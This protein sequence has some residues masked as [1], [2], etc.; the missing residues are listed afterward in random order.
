MQANGQVEATERLLLDEYESCSDKTKVYAMFHLQS[1][2][3]IY[4]NSGQLEQ[5]KQ[6]AQVLLQGATRSGIGI[7]KS[8]GD[9]LLGMVY[10][11]RNELEAAAQHFTQIFENPY[12][13][14][15]SPYRD[16]LAALA[17]IHQIRGEGIEAWQMVESISRFDLEL[18]GSE[19]Q[20]TRS[21]RAR[22]QLLQGDL[23]GAS[24]WVA[25]FT[26]PPPDQ[27]FLWLEEPQVTRARI[28]VSRGTEADLEH[29]LQILDVLDEIA[30]RTH[31]TRYKIEVLA[32]QALVL[33]KQGETIRAAAILRQALDLA[34]S[35]GFVRIFIDLG[36]PMQEMLQR[37]AQRDHPGEILPR[38]LAAYPGE[39]NYPGGKV[40][41]TVQPQAGK[42]ALAEPLTPR[43]FEILE[44]LREPLSIKEIAQKLS[45]THATV[46]RHTINL[47]GKLGVNKRRD[48][49]AKAEE[50]NILPRR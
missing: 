42:S 45:I 9:W 5:V 21:L 1:L 15:I 41:R 32:L 47:Y 29:R 11:H 7:M 13:A 30:E 16:A 49:V 40:T 24:N 22:L 37:L 10:Y 14:H 38:I 23:E 33:D 25:T 18:G 2:G 46:K 12:I 35:G 20:R 39:N 4:L 50:L 8:W 19:D 31:N 48:A 44:L 17:L 36:R 27:A 28:L 3:I 43:E 6:I 26:E 34:R